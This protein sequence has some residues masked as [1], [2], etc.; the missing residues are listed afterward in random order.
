MLMYWYISIDLLGFQKSWALGF[1]FFCQRESF[2]YCGWDSLFYLADVCSAPGMTRNDLTSSSGFTISV[3]ERIT[4]VVRLQ[5]FWGTNYT[6]FSINGIVHTQRTMLRRNL[7][8]LHDRLGFWRA[9]LLEKWFYMR[10][11]CLI[12]RRNDKLVVVVGWFYEVISSLILSS[13]SVSV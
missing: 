11:W 4:R 10:P 13:R 8:E 9:C 2:L 7:C 12:R 3:L 1:S 5:L 6:I